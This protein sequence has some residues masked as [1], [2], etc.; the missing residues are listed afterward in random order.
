MS[1]IDEYKTLKAE[2]ED[3]IEKLN[4]CMGAFAKTDSKKFDLQK[5]KIGFSVCSICYSSEYVIK[6]IITYGYTDSSKI[7]SATDYKVVKGIA[8]AISMYIPEIIPTVQKLLQAEIDKARC[9]A[10][11]E[12][13]EIMGDLGLGKNCECE[14]SSDIKD[15]QA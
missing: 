14:K 7:F 3:A 1:K 4:W 2:N 9:Q 5:S 10:V 13:K 8:D 6:P 15:F 11:D 12:I